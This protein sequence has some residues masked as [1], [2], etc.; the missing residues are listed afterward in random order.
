MSFKVIEVSERSVLFKDEHEAYIRLDIHQNHKDGLEAIKEFEH[1][2]EYDLELN[3]V[4]KK[5]KIMKEE[6]EEKEKEE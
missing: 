3:P 4:K 2:H 1:G 6:E 5:K